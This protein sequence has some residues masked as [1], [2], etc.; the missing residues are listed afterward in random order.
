MLERACLFRFF[1]LHHHYFC[2][3]FLMLFF[4]C[5]WDF[6]YTPASN[7]FS[8]SLFWAENFCRIFSLKLLFLNEGTVHRHL[9]QARELTHMVTEGTIHQLFMDI[10]GKPSSVHIR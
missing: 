3:A 2:N 7:C 4:F 1:A 5:V 10:L 8:M 9:G 6:H